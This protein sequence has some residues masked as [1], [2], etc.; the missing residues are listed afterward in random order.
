[1]L[2]WRVFFTRRELGLPQASTDVMVDVAALDD[3]LDEYGIGDGS[4]YLIDPL[5]RYDVDLNDYFVTMLAN[6][7]DTTQAAVAYDLKRF[8][9]FLWDNRGRRSWKAASPDDRAA[10]KHW[11]LHDAAGPRVEA[12]TW[13][14]EVATVN[15]FYRWAVVEGHAA[16]NPFR[17]RVSRSR[18]PRRPSGEPTPAEASHEGRPNDVEWL[19][20]A[21][22]R[23]WRD[24]GVR[25]FTPHG[26]PDR[27]FR[28]RF[29]SRN[30]AFTD[31][32]I[33]TGLRL[34]EQTSLSLFEL[35]E[36]VPGTLN[37][38]TW[39]PEA[40]AKGGSARR[41]Y[42]P[43]SSLKDVW[44][45]VETDRAEAVEVAREKGLYER[46]RKPLIVSDPCKP[47]VV[48]DGERLPIGQLDHRERRRVLIETPQG[49]EPAALWLNRHGLPSHPSGWQ[50]MFKTANSPR[51]T[52][53]LHSDRT[54]RSDALAVSRSTPRPTR[55]RRPARPTVDRRRNPTRPGQVHRPV[56][57]RRGSPG[58][59]PGPHARHPHPSRRPVA[60]GI[61]RRLGRLCRRRQPPLTTQ[62]ER[63]ERQRERLLIL[64]GRIGLYGVAAS[65][66]GEAGHGTV[67]SAATS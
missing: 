56:R 26:L 51:N 27:S 39:L 12:T 18:D 3:W 66:D 40:I 41:I 8:L 1:M 61:G 42:F 32:L 36:P 15:Q 29:A 53:P 16:R 24:T 47:V 33:R 55:Q 14:R 58:R 52:P 19:P 59:D 60:E 67:V 57:P 28:G 2:G 22:Y 34:S 6:E 30:S 23:L 65:D 50:E 43:V 13:D 45:Y 25:G 38:R 20:P 10:F 11:R 17:Q 31:S 37:F 64:E 62:N 35:P 5:G 46:I 44:D 48:I 49:L 63:V 4:P 21:T 54:R 7:P 9:K